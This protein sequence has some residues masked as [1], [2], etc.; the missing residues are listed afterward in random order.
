MTAK[1][2]TARNQSRPMG[3]SIP[4]G[5]H[6]AYESGD[7]AAYYDGQIVGYRATYS[8]AESLL[9]GHVYD[10]LKRGTV[11]VGAFAATA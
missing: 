8:E 11:T 10:L 6:I 5:K 7:Y 2:K 3:K 4:M 1:R 9:D